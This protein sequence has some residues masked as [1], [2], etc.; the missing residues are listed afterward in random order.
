MIR[1]YVDNEIVKPIQNFQEHWRA[2]TLN[3]K[4]FPLLTSIS[5]SKK[6]RKMHFTVQFVTVQIEYL[7]Q[8]FNLGNMVISALMIWKTLILITGSESPV[9]VVLR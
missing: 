7:A 3:L 8:L 6:M 4:T 1:E 2:V 5:F 9:V